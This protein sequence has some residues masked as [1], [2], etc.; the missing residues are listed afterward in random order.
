MEFEKFNRKKLLDVEDYGR[1][2]V[3]LTQIGSD[4]GR[5]GER[6]DE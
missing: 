5:K 2:F 6:Y 1:R 4:L 3:G